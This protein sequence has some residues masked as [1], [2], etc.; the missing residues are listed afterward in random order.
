MSAPAHPTGHPPAGYP[1][2]W[3]GFGRL[4]VVVTDYEHPPTADE[5]AAGECPADCAAAVARAR[6]LAGVAI[7]E[8]RLAWVWV[9]H[10]GPYAPGTW[11]WFLRIPPPGW[12]DPETERRE[13]ELKAWYAGKAAT[14]EAAKIARKAAAVARAAAREADK[15]RRAMGDEFD[16]IR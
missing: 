13:R 16:A 8:D 11:K 12:P 6:E 1:P 9:G 10:D 15:S 14:E 4:R 3:L 5:W 2:E 7:A